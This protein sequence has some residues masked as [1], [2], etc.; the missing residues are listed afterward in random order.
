MFSTKAIS[1]AVTRPLNSAVAHAVSMPIARSSAVADG[2]PPET[3]FVV[4]AHNEEAHIE[5]TLRSISSQR[6][7]G[8]YEV[9]VVDDGSTDATAHVAARHAATEP[10]VTVIRLSENRGRG[11]A[12]ATGVDAARGRLIATVDA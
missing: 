4:M 5:R 11:H 12:R 9:V 10:A 2:G 6:G 7:L 1:T 3:S 8:N